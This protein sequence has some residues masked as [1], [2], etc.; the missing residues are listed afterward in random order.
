MDYNLEYFCISIKIAKMGGDKIGTYNLSLCY[1]DTYA[2]FENIQMKWKLT[3]VKSIV[4]EIE[5]KVSFE[6]FS[7]NICRY[8]LQPS[9]AILYIAMLET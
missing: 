5:L 6:A 8:L 2:K 4:L 1:D 3:N 7:T 9:S